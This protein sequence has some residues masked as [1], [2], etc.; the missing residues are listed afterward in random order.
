MGVY[1]VTGAASGMGAASADRLRAAGHTV[2][3]V[4]LKEADV[5]ADLSTPAGRSVAVRRTLER[6]GSR[7]DG[8]VLAAGLGPVPGKE[9]TLA[10]VN[11]RGV[12]ELLEG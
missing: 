3:T 1:A 10:E 4:D 11:V 6:A 9:H 12:I 2:I 7:L 5:V 8:A